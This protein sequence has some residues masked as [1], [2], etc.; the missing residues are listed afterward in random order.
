MLQA[1]PLAVTTP[2]YNG[3][4]LVPSADDVQRISRICGSFY[5][6]SKFPGRPLRRRDAVVEKM[7]REVG[8]LRPLRQTMGT[9]RFRN[10]GSQAPDD[11]Q[12]ELTDDAV[13]LP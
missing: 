8:T 13:K 9:V 12:I 2:Y 4:V 11:W 6:T 3:R 1:S 7:I 5:V 10:A